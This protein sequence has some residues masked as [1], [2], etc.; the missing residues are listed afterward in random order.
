M[1]CG[2]NNCNETKS[3][4]RAICDV[5]PPEMVAQMNLAWDEASYP[6]VYIDPRG[7]G[8]KLLAAMELDG[9]DENR[10]G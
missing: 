6:A 2:M 8:D 4:S 5:L 10:P 3:L 9:L 1:P 7:V